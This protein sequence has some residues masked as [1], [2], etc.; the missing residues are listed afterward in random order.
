[1]LNLEHATHGWGTTK[2]AKFGEAR[3]TEFLDAA[4]AWLAEVEKDRGVSVTGEAPQPISELR[5]RPRL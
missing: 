5:L 1:M 3:T 2:R 4:A